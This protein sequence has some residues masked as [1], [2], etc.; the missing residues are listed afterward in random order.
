MI[1]ASAASCCKDM[2]TVCAPFAADMCK[3]MTKFKNDA[4]FKDTS[5]TV[6]CGMA[7]VFLPDFTASKETCAEKV[8][9][10]EGGTTARKA[11]IANAA[12]T[13]CPDSESVCAGFDGALSNST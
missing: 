6:S 12:P 7:R 11:M 4:N 5:G 10:G 2:Q 1:T 9:N 8:P 13:C 3:D